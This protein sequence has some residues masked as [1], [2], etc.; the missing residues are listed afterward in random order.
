MSSSLY[1]TFGN[2]V[3]YRIAG[4]KLVAYLE[5]ATIRFPLPEAGTDILATLTDEKNPIRDFVKLD[6]IQVKLEKQ[7]YKKANARALAPVLVQVAQAQ[8]IDPLDFFDVNQNSLNLTVDA[9]NAINT[10]RPAGS[11]VGIATSIK[12]QRSPA[13]KLIKP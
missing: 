3:D 8:G 4:G 10:M 11:R 7:G 13:T 5:E 6:I 12:N 2:T 9:Y 1:N